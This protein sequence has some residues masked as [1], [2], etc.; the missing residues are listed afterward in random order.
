MM[1]TSALFYGHGAMII[2]SAIIAV[3][4]S[5]QRTIVSCLVVASF[6]TAGLLLL[7]G[8]ALVALIVVTLNSGMLWF[9][10]RPMSFQDREPLANVSGERSGMLL[11]CLLVVQGLAAA[12]LTF[13]GSGFPTFQSVPIAEESSVADP[14][15]PL[16]FAVS[17][18]VVLQALV[19]SVLFTIRDRKQH[20]VAPDERER[21][22]KDILA[23]FP[24][25]R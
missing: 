19:S 16:F 1:I 9:L 17:L 15:N 25:F 3:L 13:D 22:P 21:A 7:L 18:L 4:A 23:E 8:Q 5:S 2:M 20:G 10:F 6:S 24:D 12:T 11:A 14:A